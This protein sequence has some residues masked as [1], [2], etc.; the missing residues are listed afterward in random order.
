MRYKSL[1]IGSY[2]PYSYKQG[3]IRKAWVH[4]LIYEASYN[5]LTLEKYMEATSKKDFSSKYT[6][7]NPA[8]Y[9]VPS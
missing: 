1:K 4:R 8:Q 6:S 7:F 9:H 2:Y 5:N 3:V